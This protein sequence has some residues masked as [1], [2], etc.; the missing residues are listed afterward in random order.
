MSHLFIFLTN[1][2]RLVLYWDRH[3]F[4]LW[5]SSDFVLRYLIFSL[6]NSYVEYL[7]ST[8]FCYRYAIFF[9][10]SL[11]LTDSFLKISSS[12]DNV[13]LLLRSTLSLV[14][15]CLI[16]VFSFH[17]NPQIKE[18]S[19]IVQSFSFVILEDILRKVPLSIRYVY[20]VSKELE[21]FNWNLRNIIFLF[22]WF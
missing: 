2:L 20:N 13:D 1:F 6:I 12:L 7:C 4:S 11:V 10:A 22:V 8:I 5:L 17:I 15:T 14:S 19:H 21:S 9:E 18:N 16:Y 3:L